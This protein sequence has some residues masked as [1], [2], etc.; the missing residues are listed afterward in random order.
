MYLQNGE[1]SSQKKLLTSLIFILH[2][3]KYLDK[4]YNDLKDQI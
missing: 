2:V 1:N 3:Q 4:V